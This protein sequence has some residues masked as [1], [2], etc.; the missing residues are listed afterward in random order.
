LTGRF[1]GVSKRTRLVIIG[2]LVVSVAL[3]SLYWW[4]AQAK[5]TRYVTQ[6]LKRGEISSAVQATGTINPMTTVPVGSFVSGTVQYIF[7]DYNSRVREG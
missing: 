4:K 2:S 3:A 5:T 7:A 1:T 6:V